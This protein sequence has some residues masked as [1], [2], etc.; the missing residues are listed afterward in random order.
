M[1]KSA[2]YADS[3]VD[4]DSADRAKARLAKLVKSTITGK[5][6]GD[7]GNFGAAFPLK[8]VGGTDSF[9]VSSVDGVG[10]KLN[11]AVMAGRHDTIGHDLVNHLTDDILCM[12][13]KPLFFMDYIGLGRL[14]EDTVVSIVEGFA[15]GCKE[16]G[17]GLIGG[18]T[19]EMPGMYAENDYDLAGFMV[20]VAEKSALPNKNKIKPGDRLIGFSSSGLHTNGYSLARRAFFDIGKMSLDDP[21]PETGKKLGDELLAVHRSYFSTLFPLIQRKLIK[22]LAHITGGGFE[23]NISRI[24][25]DNV[26]ANVDTTFW[27]PAGIFK[28]IQRLAD[29]ET[30]EMY[31][32]FNMGIG[33][34]AIA[35]EK[36]IPAIRKALK[37]PNCEV[38]PAGMITE[39]SGKVKL[40]F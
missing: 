38:V 16:N 10:T 35:A 9:L 20:G 29:V 11:V 40:V 15:N 18:E 17:C 36:D 21:L 30:E 26:D 22:G 4:I 6:H 19:A 28:A 33:M 25:P 13:A 5:S 27:F 14:N 39:G 8:S 32:V 24:L 1:K 37:D 12:G 31:R 23:G 3:G 2:K 34:I 7:F